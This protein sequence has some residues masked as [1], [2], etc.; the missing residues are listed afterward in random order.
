MSEEG[1]AVSRHEGKKNSR[2]SPSKNQRS[3]SERAIKMNQ[4]LSF[5]P[6]IITKRVVTSKLQLSFTFGGKFKSSASPNDA[7][8]SPPGFCSYHSGFW[9]SQFP[10]EQ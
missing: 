4:L 10:P 2:N 1:K 8:H 5:L 9:L 7:R 6:P 3:S